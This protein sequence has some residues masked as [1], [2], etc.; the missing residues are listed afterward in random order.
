MYEFGQDEIDAL[1]KVVES[2]QLFRYLGPD[3]PTQCSL[4]EAELAETFKVPYAVALTSGTAALATALT[5]LGIGPGDEVI[6][7]AYTFVAT[8]AAVLQVGAIP[9]IGNIDEG[10][11]LCPLEVKELI[12]ARTKAILPVHIDG[13]PASMEPL[14]KIS[15]E[16]DLYVVEDAA[17]AIGGHYHGAPLGQFGE[18]GC[19]SF[20]ELKTITSGEGGAV[21]LKDRAPYERAL[22]FHDFANQFG[23]THQQTYQTISPFIGQTYRLSELQGALLRVQLKKLSSIIAKLRER[24]SIMR[25]IFE[26]HGLKL[27]LGHDPEGDAGHSL[28]VSFDDVDLCLNACQKLNQ[29]QIPYQHI[30]TRPAHAAWQWGHLLSERRF[31]HPKL[32]PYQWSED[33]YSYHKALFLPTLGILMS[34]LK[35]STDYNLSLDDTKSAAEKIAQLIAKP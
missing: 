32:D 18:A 16:H 2:R 25:E 26:S 27:R 33:S 34:T 15:R 12:T 5:A 30:Q 19:F 14:L 22:C 29:Q 23:P 20:N 28:H 7:P 3:R 17:Q 24:K 11:T 9:V 10:L 1:K 35:F 6:I 8:P 21:L 4:F 31:A 13:L